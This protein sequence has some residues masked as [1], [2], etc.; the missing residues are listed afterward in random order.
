MIC[1]KNKF[2]NSFSFFL[3]MSSVVTMWFLC[4]SWFCLVLLHHWRTASDLDCI[5]ITKYIPIGRGSFETARCVFPAW[6][7]SN[8]DCFR[9]VTWTASPYC[10]GGDRVLA[11]RAGNDGPQTIGRWSVCEEQHTLLC[12]SEQFRRGGGS[13]E[14]VD[15]WGKHQGRER[16][17][18]ANRET[19]WMR[20]IQDLESCCQE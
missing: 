18:S 12:V 14:G 9:W 17:R 5:L 11:C 16:R 19:S 10:H 15:C 13:L 1:N 7:V 2:K 8:S 4:L 6:S 20:G 3:Q